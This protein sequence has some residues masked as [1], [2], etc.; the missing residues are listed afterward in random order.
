M[1]PIS[2]IEAINKK[3]HIKRTV[4]LILFFQF[5]FLGA[6]AQWTYLKLGD[7]S[8]NNLT[9]VSDTIYAS[10]N[11][12]IY[13]KNVLNNNTNWLPCG[14]QGNNVV[15]TI[16]HDNNQTFISVIEIEDTYTTQIYKSIDAGS[17]FTLMNQNISDV[18]HYNCL[19]HIAYPD[20]NY[21]TLFFLNHHLK[22][23]DGGN[24]WDTI[25]SSELTSR[26]IKIHP[27]KD[28][29]IIIGG[30]TSYLSPYLQISN[31]YGNTFTL[32]PM[33]TFFEGDNCVH[34]LAIDDSTWYAAGEGVIGKTSNNGDTWTQ[35]LN[36][37]NPPPNLEEFGLYYT[38]IAFSPND[39]NKLY[40][41]GLKSTGSS[42]VCLLYYDNIGDSWNYYSSNSMEPQQKI[43]CMTIRKDENVDKVY[44]G[45]KGVYL[46]EKPANNID[47]LQQKENALNIYPNPVENLL[48][49]DSECNIERVNIF[50]IKGEKIL[51]VTDTKTIDV[52]NLIQGIFVI[53]IITD[54][55]IYRRNFIKK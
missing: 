7:K 40:V 12:G 15:Q 23:F 29:L 27:N 35:L 8:V 3:N 2:P 18:N 28:S 42:K 33:L 1:K 47:N 26:F 46:F 55:R 48:T 24:S 41:T 50:N 14:K 31:N 21:D 11:D 32:N 43:K 34:D 44:L 53:K 49:I 54:K 5:I 37:W 4:F 17:T 10:T 30:E 51:A 6:F 19:D 13:K 38:D 20:N 22:T 25:N 16:V 36:L 39:K 45:G 52:S 9:I